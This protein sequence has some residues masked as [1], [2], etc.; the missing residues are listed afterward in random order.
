MTVS[1]RATRSTSITTKSRLD[2][3]QFTGGIYQVNIN[4]DEIGV[5][6]YYIFSCTARVSERELLAYEARQ[7]NGVTEVIK[8]VSSVTAKLL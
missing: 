7:Y 5:Q 1:S 3:R 2:N 8:C 6:H 4:Y